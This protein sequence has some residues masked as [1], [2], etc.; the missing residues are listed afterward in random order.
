MR[1]LLVDSDMITRSQPRESLKRALFLSP[2]H[3]KTIAAT[4]SSVPHQ[5]MK[6]K[7]AL[8]SSPVRQAETKSLDGT[9]SD[10]FL[11]RKRDFDEA[12]NSRSKI[13]KSL[14]F[15]G[16]SIGSSQSV[17]FSRR[18][19]EVLATRT[20]A[21]LNE[22]HK[23]K[24]LWAVTEAL[25]LHGWRMSSAGFREKASALAQLTRKLLTLPPHAAKLAAPKLST[26]DTLF[27][28]ARRYVFAIIQGRTVEECFQDEQIKLSTETN[29]LSGYISATAYQQMKTKQAPC[30]LTSQIKEN[31]CNDGS[32]KQEQPRSTSKNILQD[33][34]VNIDTNSNSSSSG[35]GMLDKIG[36]FRSNSMP[37]FE[38][39]AKMRARRQISFD[40]VDFPKR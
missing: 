16:D 37:S 31:T 18:A 3:K 20:M 22:T 35:F 2:E 1:R 25:R 8:F 23:K 12:D 30:T 24:L 11:K 9:S 32:L 39:A 5:A 19:S 14:S 27:K 17:T 10:Q 40:N 4:T 21:E 6:S 7:R 33:K 29:K 28:L 34:M 13:A 15:G 26:S 38:E 36:V